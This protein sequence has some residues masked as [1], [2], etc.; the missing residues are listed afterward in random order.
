MQGVTSPA[1]ECRSELGGCGATFELAGASEGVSTDELRQ[2]LDAMLQA[3][4][5]FESQEPQGTHGERLPYS[6][7][8]DDLLSTLRR[9]ITHMSTLLQS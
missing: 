6:L 2:A 9:H 4:N 1:Y 5:A 8:T 7:A 3:I